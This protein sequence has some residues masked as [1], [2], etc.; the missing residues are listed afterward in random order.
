[1]K[2][3]KGDPSTA[4]AL[5]GA[6]AETA[7]LLMAVSTYDDLNLAACRLAH[8][9]FG[10]PKL[11]AQTSDPDMAEELGLMGVRVVQPQMATALALE[12]A[13]YFPAVFDILANPN[14]GIDVREVRLGNPRFF[15]ELLRNVRLPG[16]ALVM[17]LRRRGEVLVPRGDTRLRKDDLLMLVGHI[18]SLNKAVAHL[19]TPS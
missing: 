8:R 5:R 16:N 6:G 14:D 11:I 18:D 13:L 2:V 17:G 9:T 4:K 1:M 15:G 3:I 12:G 19:G 7:E 10:V